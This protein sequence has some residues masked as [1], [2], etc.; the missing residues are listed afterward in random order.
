[1]AITFTP[2]AVSSGE[3]AQFNYKLTQARGVP[4]QIAD[5]SG[6]RVISGNNETGAVIAYGVPVAANAS[7]VLPNSCKL[8]TAAGAILGISV[9]TSVNEKIGIPAPGAAPSYTEGV[10][11]LKS[12]NV[13]TQGTIYLQVMED[14]A[15]GDTLR[16]HKS[17]A[18]AGKWGKTASAG[19]TLALAAGGWVIRKGGSTSQVLALE[20]NTPAQ[21]SF[22]ADN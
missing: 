9:R 6:S 13:L 3:G 10:P 12:V 4:G 16:F 11:D 2:T 17:G 19:N 15:P 22:T 5:L 20:I 14:V 1:M 18:N 8:A 7:G 21:L